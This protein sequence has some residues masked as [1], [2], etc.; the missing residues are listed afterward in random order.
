MVKC[1]NSI[2]HNAKILLKNLKV[3][4]TTAGLLILDITNTNF[5]NV[6]MRPR[7]VQQFG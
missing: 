2:Y 3:W 7:S 5:T 1:K 4:F 6:M